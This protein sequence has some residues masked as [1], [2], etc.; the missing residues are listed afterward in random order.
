MLVLLLEPDP[1]I[2]PFMASFQPGITIKRRHWFED[3]GQQV[4]LIPHLL[5]S[6]ENSIELAMSLTKRK[7]GGSIYVLID[8]RDT[9]AV[10]V[11]QSLELPTMSYFCTLFE[12]RD[13][14]RLSLLKKILDTI[15]IGCLL[16]THDFEPLYQ[17]KV[18]SASTSLQSIKVNINAVL[19]S[20]FSKL[21]YDG[22][23]ERI[24]LLN[25]HGFAQNKR[26][27]VGNSEYVL[28]FVS[29][30]RVASETLSYLD[31]VINLSIWG[32]D[33]IVSTPRFAQFQETK[34][35]SKTIISEAIY[36]LD[37]VLPDS[38]VFNVTDM[39]DHAFTCNYSQ[40]V[41]LMV[42]C[43]LKV[44]VLT[45]WGG[46]I[47]IEVLPRIESGEGVIY[48]SGSNSAKRKPQIYDLS[49][50]DVV[51]NH[52]ERF[53][54]EIEKSLGDLEENMNVKIDWGLNQNQPTCSIKIF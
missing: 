29:D 18:F 45:G 25:F 36:S 5:A 23:P 3:F 52:L 15:P 11:L 49:Y 37:K 30:S 6:K 9:F 33:S 26:I 46:N 34:P 1:M 41:K 24:E 28:S 27:L 35:T 21:P 22:S 2:K 32:L 4:T 7:V 13:T 40:A 31:L 51:S 42:Y 48:V 14:G 53:I 47:E 20:V 39:Y 8:P 10:Q 54:Q 43:L 19:Q 50:L 12:D 17:N 16:F 38:F 44:C